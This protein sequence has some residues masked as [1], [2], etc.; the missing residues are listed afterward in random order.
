[1]TPRQSPNI[2]LSSLWLPAVEW[3]GRLNPGWPLFR[4]RCFWEDPAEHRQD[5]VLEHLTEELTTSPPSMWG[6]CSF[7][8]GTEEN[9]GSCTARHRIQLTLEAGEAPVTGPWS[10]CLRNVEQPSGPALRSH[11]GP[12]LE[13]ETLDHSLKKLGVGE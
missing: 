8:E 6:L 4:L 13:L 3:C 10:P 11:A 7:A 9:S 5:G 1:M 2:G 12:D